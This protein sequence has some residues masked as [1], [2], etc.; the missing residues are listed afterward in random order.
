MA[1]TR[2]SASPPRAG[3][4]HSTRL[5]VV[6]YSFLLVATPFIMLRAYMQE[7]VGQLTRI[8]VEIAGREIVIVPW[9]VLVLFLAILV[10]ARR[11]LTPLRIAAGFIALAL[12][13][14]A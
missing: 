8:Y 3:W 1:Q 7:A 13:A 14:L 5:H 6:L 11:H 10:L 12:V 2:P 9:A 4:I